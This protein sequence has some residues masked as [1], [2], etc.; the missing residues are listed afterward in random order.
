MP[1]I[2]VAGYKTR[3]RNPETYRDLVHAPPAPSNYKDPAKIAEYKQVKLAEFNVLAPWLKMTGALEQIYALDLTLEDEFCPLYPGDWSSPEELA[4][5]FAR[6]L[7]SHY[8]FP[9]RPFG[10]EPPVLFYGFNLKP[11]LRLTGV[12]ANR[13]S[14]QADANSKPFRVPLGLWYGN[15]ACFDPKEMLVE[16]EAKQ[17][18]SLSKICAEAPAGPIALPGNY[19]LHEDAWQDTRVALELVL[20]YRLTPELPDMTKG[21]LSVVA[22]GNAQSEEPVDAQDASA[23]DEY[24]DEDEPADESEVDVTDIDPEP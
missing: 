2:I 6:W 12:L 10:G 4:Y 13:F 18:I 15:D 3:L 11:L 19:R 23:E 16:Q 21:F 14:V 8:A 5:L 17:L 20:Q 1:G 7:C 9:D 24:A 22:E